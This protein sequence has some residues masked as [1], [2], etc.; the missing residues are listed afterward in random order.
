[1]TIDELL[2]GL[3]IVEDKAAEAKKQINSYLDGAYVP[4]SRFN[5]VNEEKKT[6]AAAVSERDKQLEVLKKSTGDVEG[7]KKQ[8]KDLQEANKKAKEESEQALKDL[9]INDAIKMAVVGDAQDVDI[10]SS[11]VDKS[12]IILGED[13]KI[14]GLKEQVEEL[15]KNKAF[16]F[17][18]VQNPKYNPNGGNGE[19][20]ANPF[21]KETFNLTEQGKLF[22]ENPEQARALAQAAGVKI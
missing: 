18:N 7:F 17:K 20:A 8:I 12:K 22:R 2:K 13:G 4:K 21:A 11:L 1:M 3:G 9:K 15:K 14:T 10:V 16:L 19:P 5:E 6:M